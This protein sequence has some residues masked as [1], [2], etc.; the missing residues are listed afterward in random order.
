MTAL[1]DTE[2]LAKET[3]KNVLRLLSALKLILL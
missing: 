1:K 3:W 2:G